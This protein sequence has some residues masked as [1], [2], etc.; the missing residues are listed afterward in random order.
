MD[1]SESSKTLKTF[2]IVH[3]LKVLKRLRNLV[4]F[5]NYGN[6]ISLSHTTLQLEL[7]GTFVMITLNDE[8]IFLENSW[9][10]NKM[11]LKVFSTL[12]TMPLTVF[13]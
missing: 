9:D 8:L 7:I 12:R 3:F 6:A 2:L 4:K 5:L 13:C 10:E 11:I 1:I